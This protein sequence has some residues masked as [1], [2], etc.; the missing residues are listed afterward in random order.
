MF[1]PAIPHA[2]SR[3]WLKG[4]VNLHALRLLV[5]LACCPELVPF[6]LASRVGEQPAIAAAAHSRARFRQSPA[7]SRSS[8]PTNPTFSFAPS[9]EQLTSFKS[10]D[11]TKRQFHS[12]I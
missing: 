7:S 2:L 8:T 9:R 6:I 11:G 12:A 10:A 4:D 3:L 5:N 1:V